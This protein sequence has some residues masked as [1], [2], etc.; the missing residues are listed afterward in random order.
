MDGLPRGARVRFT[1][2]FTADGKP[3]NPAEVSCRVRTPAGTRTV[4]GVRRVR[5]GEYSAEL[6]LLDLGELVVTFEA[7]TGEFTEQ[8]FAVVNAQPIAVGTPAYA[9]PERLDERGDEAAP[10]SIEREETAP[11][12]VSERPEVKEWVGS[13]LTG[14]S[15]KAPAAPPWRK[16]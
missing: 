14:G 16:P 2:R 5:D 1:A 3:R 7:D 10:S 11:V 12:A 6:V 8:R 4:P 9:S 15:K 13:I